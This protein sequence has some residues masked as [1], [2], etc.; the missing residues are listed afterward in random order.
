M[1]SKPSYGS[2]NTCSIIITVLSL[3]TN[4]RQ[5]SYSDGYLSTAPSFCH[6]RVYVQNSN[7]PAKY[8]AR[9]HSIFLLLLAHSKQSA[10]PDH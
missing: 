10:F 6:C 8:N 3:L 4:T 1:K 5:L 7:F 9:H 2:L